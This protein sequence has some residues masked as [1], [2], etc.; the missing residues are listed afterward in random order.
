MCRSGHSVT[1]PF[2]MAIPCWLF[3]SEQVCLPFATSRMYE[4]RRSAAESIP[5][6]TATLP[7]SISIQCG[8]SSYSAEFVDI[9]IVGDGALNGVPRPVVKR[10]SWAPAAVSAVEET[11][12]FP[13][14]HRRFSPL[15]TTRSP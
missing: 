15:H 8:F 14:A 1:P 11:R 2:Q 4:S 10:M 5:S 6:P 3:I 13:G 12:S 9:F 7:V